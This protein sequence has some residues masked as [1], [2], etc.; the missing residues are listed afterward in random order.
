MAEAL[1]EREAHNAIESK[2]AGA[3]EERQCGAE[4]LIALLEQRQ[5]TYGMLSRLYYGEVDQ[6][7]LDE[8]HGM[9]FPVSVGD[10]D[11]DMGYWLIATYLSNIWSGTLTELSIDFARC[12]L[13]N[14]GKAFSSAYPY[15]SVYTSERRLLMQDARMEVL[16]LYR[17]AGFDKTEDW[18]EGEDHIALELEFEKNLC[19]RSIEALR[20]GDERS[21]YANL[22]TQMNF[23]ENHL[24][25]WIP[26][27]AEDV[28]ALAQTDFYHGLAFL[29]E[30]FLKNDDLF[31]K[32]LLG[33]EK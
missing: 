19:E 31:L 5:S 10:K 33:V 14:G 6:D 20:A 28:H 1:L 32:S 3:T 7:L 22:T 23:L 4:E 8:M 26:M 21:A 24:L 30:G 17:A 9:L 18:H 27:L 2:A 11:A 16:A 12:F 13:S 15:E 25:N 29:T